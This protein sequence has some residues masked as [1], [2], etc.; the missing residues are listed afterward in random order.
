MPVH[1][2]NRIDSGLRRIRM[3]LNTDI[4]SVQA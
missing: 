4:D 1:A 3:T 2:K